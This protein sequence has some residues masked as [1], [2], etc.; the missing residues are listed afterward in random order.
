LDAPPGGLAGT[1]RKGAIKMV[2]S[3]VPR[4]NFG[5]YDPGLEAPGSS[6]WQEEKI[7]AR[8]EQRIIDFISEML[9][10]ARGYQVRLGTV[11]TPVAMDS[12]LTDAAAELCYDA[13]AGLTII[14]IKL[15]VAPREIATG[16]TVSVALKGVGTIS[17]AG[18]AFIPLPLLQGG[19]GASGSARAANNGGVTVTAETTLNT[20]KIFEF[21]SNFTQAPTTIL[22]AMALLPVALANAK[23]QYIGKGPACIYLQL[24]AATA[25]PLTHSHLNVIELLSTSIG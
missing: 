21:E 24:G 23:L 7:S 11:T 16:L 13:L 8:G 9:Q 12:V 25:F 15:S 10:E 14:P 3:G 19:A 18:T 17:S 4:Q 5:W 6:S 20:V 1:E 22:G 2:M